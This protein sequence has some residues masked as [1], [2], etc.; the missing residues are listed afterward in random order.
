MTLKQLFKKV[1]KRVGGSVTIAAYLYSQEP[2]EIVITWRFTERY[3]QVHGKN[4]KDAY[5][6]FLKREKELRGEG[7]EQETQGGE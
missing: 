1:E 4:T 7:N 2:N 3:E 5:E 6:K